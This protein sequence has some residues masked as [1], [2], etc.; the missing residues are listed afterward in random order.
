MFIKA[1]DANSPNTYAIVDG[2]MVEKHIDYHDTTTYSFDTYWFVSKG[3]T[4]GGLAFGK[5]IIE[6]HNDLAYEFDKR[7]HY[8]GMSVDEVL[9]LSSDLPNAQNNPNS[10]VHYKAKS[11][12][13]LASAIFGDGNVWSSGV[14]DETFK[15]LVDTWFNMPNMPEG[16]TEWLKFKKN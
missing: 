12:K 14:S 5:L 11:V 16:T 15:K 3:A 13:S 8:H 10:Y 6:F 1:T 2:S 4:K 7:S 9:A